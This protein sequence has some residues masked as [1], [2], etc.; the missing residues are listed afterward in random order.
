[1]I[2]LTTGIY[3]I[4]KEKQIQIDLRLKIQIP[5]IQESVSPSKSHGL[6]Q[7]KKSITGSKFFADNKK[8][9]Q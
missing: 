1:M 7:T 2:N 8:G 9:T 3:Q 4:I 5:K 6:I